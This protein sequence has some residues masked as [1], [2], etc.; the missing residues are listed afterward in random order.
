MMSTMKE[1]M[2]TAS[3]VLTAINSNETLSFVRI[4]ILVIWPNYF[5]I[6][7]KVFGQQKE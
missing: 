6:N 4:T 5:S 2:V 3:V 1:N 7:S